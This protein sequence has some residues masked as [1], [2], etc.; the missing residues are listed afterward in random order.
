MRLEMTKKYD[1][2]GDLLSPNKFYVVS[3]SGEIKLSR[4]TYAG[5]EPFV[6]FVKAGDYIEL[7]PSKVKTMLKIE[8]RETIPFTVY[9]SEA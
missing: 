3:S 2:V 4:L 5:V 8:S 7:R 6:A 1:V 9:V